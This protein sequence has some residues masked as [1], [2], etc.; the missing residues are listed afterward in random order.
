[1]RK[2]LAEALY[3]VIEKKEY[4]NLYLRNHLREVE[5]KDR[6]LATRIFYGTL[7]NHAYCRHIWKAFV[8]RNPSKTT[9]IVLDMSVYQLLFL[10]KVPDYAVIDQAV[11]I[12]KTHH[13]KE[14]GLVN[15]VLHKV[16]S[17]KPETMED[18]WQQLAFQTS[19]PNWLIKMWKAQYGEEKTIQMANSSCAIL[20]VYVR[21][22][23]C[24][25]PTLSDMFLPTET[26]N[27]YIYIGDS[28]TNTEEYRNGQV[29]VQDI[30]SYQI[31]RM[32]DPQP[33]ETIL[34]CCAAPGTKSFAMAEMR[35]D[36]G[37]IHAGDIHAHRVEL[38]K[39]DQQR[40]GIHSVIPMQLDAT[41]CSALQDY[42]KILCDVP[43]S[44]YGVLARKPD[45]KLHMDPQDM[46]TLIPLQR[47]IMEQAARH[48][49]DGGIFVYS[50]CT[51]NKKENE[52]QIEWFLQNHRDFILLE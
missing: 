31:A 20:P 39:R 28:I 46:D 45:I 42:D 26:E 3:Q 17:R 19:C 51:M 37:I 23:A 24:A 22:N 35:N 7:Q 13:K 10:D 1:M 15:A 16:T 2:W 8:K 14:S 6:A 25:D 30:G 50:T 34:D 4:S 18:P 9:R 36:Q 47:K 21:R 49:K 11:Q 38:I 29:S 27:M 40:L 5:E 32:V 44:G 43:C 33:Q 48:L 41:D 52:K 12:V